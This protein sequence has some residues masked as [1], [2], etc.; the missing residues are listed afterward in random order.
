MAET[1]ALADAYATAFMVMGLEQAKDFLNRNNDLDA[2]FIYSNEAGEYGSFAT[3]N[4]SR[5]ITKTFE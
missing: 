3:E 1:T 5:Q 2:F 4:F